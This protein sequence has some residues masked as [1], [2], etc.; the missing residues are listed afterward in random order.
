MNRHRLALLLVIALAAT[1]ARAGDYY[2]HVIFDN[3]LTPDAYFNSRGTT[4]GGSF[5]EVVNGRLP[6][7]EL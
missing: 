5:L 1:S 3:S 4:N 2:R 7:A 6:V